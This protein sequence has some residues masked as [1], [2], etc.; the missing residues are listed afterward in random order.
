MPKITLIDPQ[1]PQNTGN[2]ARLCAA[3]HTPLD[4]V[5][6][7]GFSLEDK[8]LKRAG[9]DYWPEVNLTHHADTRAYLNL[10]NPKTTYCLTTK[11][12]RP[13]TECQFCKET[14]LVFGSETQGL[15]ESIRAQF[16]ENCI[17]IPMPNPAVRSLNLSTSV[18]IVL[19]ELIRQLQ[20]Q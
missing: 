19:Y 8:Y 17:T 5:G 6:T 16:Q 18:G 20:T 12:T 9:L 13:Y 7:L 10:L 11:S 15:S 4:L 2:I 14:T 1:I 3:T